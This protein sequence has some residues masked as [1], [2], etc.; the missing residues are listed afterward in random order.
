MGDGGG[1]LDT[2]DLVGSEWTTENGRDVP[3]VGS[4]RYFV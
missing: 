1:G 4:E 2:Q 3:Y